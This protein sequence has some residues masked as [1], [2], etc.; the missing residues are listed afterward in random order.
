[1]KTQEI[2]PDETGRGVK[3]KILIAVMSCGPYQLTRAKAVRD[4]WGSEVQGA[5]VRYFYGLGVTALHPDEIILDAPDH[6]KGFPLK[7]QAMRLWALEA[8]Y[9]KVVKVDDDVYLR[10]ERLLEAVPEASYAGRVRGPSGG[11][12]AP[13][14]SGF[15]YWLD[16][17]ALEILVKAKWNGDFAEDR[18]TATVLHQAGIRPAHD[19]RYAVVYSKNNAKSSKE[20]PLAGNPVI[21]ACEYGPEQMSQIQANFHRGIQSV[22]VYPRIEEGSLAKVEVMIKTFCRDGYLYACLN[23]LRNK[24]PDMRIN[25][26][27]DG[28]EDHQKISIYADLRYAGH[29]CNWLPYDSGFGAKANEALRHIQR[30]YVLI[31]SDDFDFGNPKVRPGVEAMVKVLDNCPEIGVV[32]GRV[33]MRAYESCLE[34]EGPIVRELKKFHGSGEVD[35]VKYHLCDLTVNYSLVRREVFEKVRW[36]GGDVKIGGG[37]HGAFFLDVKEAGWKVAVVPDAMIFQMNFNPR[38]MT[39]DYGY[40]R[41]RARAAGRPCLR[42]RGVERWILTNGVEEVA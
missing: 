38:W 26:V 35:G 32:S 42:K 9:A 39:K 6:Y 27:D 25:L 22:A 24:F 41:S 21:A 30:D 12:P 28:Y 29:S 2:Q 3:P 15:C 16:R 18:F 7:V 19:F 37:E 34:R 20:P 40:N 17:A 33:D 11:Y 36:D 31:G 5:D 14:C 23:G 13:Y 1:M 4:T 10:P 8:G